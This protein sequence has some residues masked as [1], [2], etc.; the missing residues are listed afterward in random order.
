[1][2]SIQKR[3]RVQKILE[4]Y[5]FVSIACLMMMSTISYGQDRMVL[6][7][8]DRNRQH[9][10]SDK[11]IYTILKKINLLRANGGF[12]GSTYH[13]S[14]PPLV[15]DT[16]LYRSA[17]IHAKDMSRNNYFSHFSLDDKDIGDR[18][19]D[20]GYRWLLVGENLAEGQ[21]SLKEVIHDW[22]ESQSHCEMLFNPDVTHMALARQGRYWVQHFAKP[23]PKGAVKKGDTYYILNK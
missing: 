2:R 5:T 4:T 1:M 21:E 14:A 15:W 6:K 19:D 8:T 10:L 9:S 3:I 17:L 13:S 18:L 11:H 20:L 22:K 16:A 23:A 12:C 7:N